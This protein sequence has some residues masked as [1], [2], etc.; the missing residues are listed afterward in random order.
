MKAKELI[1]ILS[2]L[3]PEIEVVFTEHYDLYPSIHRVELGIFRDHA[4]WFGEFYRENLTET[5]VELGYRNAI[6]LYPY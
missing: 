6:C 2:K 4:D 1:D 3:D 5:D